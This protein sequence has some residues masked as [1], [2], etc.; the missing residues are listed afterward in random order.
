[1]A[2]SKPG[3]RFPVSRQT[4]KGSKRTL[5]H[6][7]REPPITSLVPLGDSAGSWDLAW[8]PGSASSLGPWA[9]P[10]AAGQVLG[11]AGSSG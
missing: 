7:V 11:L 6:C 8:A 4:G 9:P 2:A 5:A 3:A 10:P 1:M